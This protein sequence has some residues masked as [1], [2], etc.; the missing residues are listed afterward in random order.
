MFDPDDESTLTGDGTPYTRPPEFYSPGIFEFP[1]DVWGIAIIFSEIIKKIANPPKNIS[2]FVP[3]PGDALKGVK[4]EH[5]RKKEEEITRR[6]TDA[7]TFIPEGEGWE[8]DILP[9]LED[10]LKIDPEARPT[11]YDLVMRFREIQKKHEISQER[12]RRE[13]KELLDCLYPKDQDS[14]P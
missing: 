4:R 6:R 2:K 14:Q 11:F 8:E 10:C 5:G 12:A 3:P 9:I 1:G 13:G 7:L